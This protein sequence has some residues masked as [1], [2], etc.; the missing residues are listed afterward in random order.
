MYM[1]RT[2]SLG[3][4]RALETLR[5]RNVAQGMV[6]IADDPR[7]TLGRMK[8]FAIAL[9]TIPVLLQG[10]GGAPRV[11]GHD[12]VAEVSR[13][14]GPGLEAV[15]IESREHGSPLSVRRQHD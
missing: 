15:S 9:K 5:S 13:G 6:K 10:Q 7:V 8:D 1:F 3:S 2:M 4:D 14:D 11:H 12:L